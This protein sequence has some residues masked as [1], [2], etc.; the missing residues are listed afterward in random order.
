MRRPAGCGISATHPIWTSVTRRRPGATVRQRRRAQGPRAGREARAAATDRSGP[1]R[2]GSLALARDPCGGESASRPHQKVVLLGEPR[3]RQLRS[4]WPFEAGGG[5]AENGE[6]RRRAP[7]LWGSA[8]R[9]AAFEASHTAGA[10]FSKVVGPNCAASTAS[11]VMGD[12]RSV[13]EHAAEARR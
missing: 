9:G 8:A 10:F 6:Y 11:C 7:R 4:D 3:R 12:P 13:R 5:E 1:F 2:K